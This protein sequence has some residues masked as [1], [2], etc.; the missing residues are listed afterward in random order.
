MKGKLASRY[1][2]LFEVMRRI[3]LVAYQLELPLMMSKV[4]DVFY[5]SLL[6]KAMV[7]PTQVL[8]Q[9]P[10]EIQEHL[11]MEI[12]PIRIVNR[13]ERELRNKEILL[14]KVL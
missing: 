3:G 11:I 2:Y 13:T 10:I 9:V 14:V 5:M 7:D 4:H 8:L 1:I 12:K 6:R